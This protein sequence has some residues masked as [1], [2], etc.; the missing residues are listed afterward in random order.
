MGYLSPHAISSMYYQDLVRGLDINVPQ[1]FDHLCSGCANGKLHHS[2]F[3][4]SSNNQYYKMELVVMDL[5]GPMFIPTWDG[6]LYA[7]VIIEVSCCYPVGR[8]LCT[9]E[10]TSIAVCDILAILERQSRFKV[11]CL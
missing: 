1:D 2:P 6:F 7:L 5:T 4:K 9:K 11:C 3:S 10:D 8:L